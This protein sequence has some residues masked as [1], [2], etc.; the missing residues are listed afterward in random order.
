MVENGEGS[1]NVVGGKTY[2]VYAY[3]DSGFEGDVIP[4]GEQMVAVPENGSVSVTMQS[5]ATNFTLELDVAVESETS[6]SVQA[7]E[8]LDYVYC[9]A[10]SP[11]YGYE[12][13]TDIYDGTGEIG[14]IEGAEWYIGCM[15][16]LN[17]DFYRSDDVVFVAT[18][19]DP[20]EITMTNAG[21]YYETQTYSFDATA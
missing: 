18:G 14:L 9:Y 19:N 13:Y 1:L 11:E 17:E 2:Y 21:F 20:L 10:Y 16:Y 7:S 5:I 6:P 8:E 12:T 3:P 15:G 4:P